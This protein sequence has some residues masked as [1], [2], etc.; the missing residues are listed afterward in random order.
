M[1]T[2]FKLGLCEGRHEIK[3]VDTYIFLD[4]DI[5]FPINPSDLRKKSCR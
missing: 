2:T 3:D 1:A 4:G 5:E